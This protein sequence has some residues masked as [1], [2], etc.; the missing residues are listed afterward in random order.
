MRLV[1]RIILAALIVVTGVLGGCASP[2][3]KDLQVVRTIPL[4]GEGGWDCI[5]V[6]SAA[7]RA[8][9]ARSTRVMVVDLAEG[10]LAGELTGVSGAHGVALVPDLNLGFATSGK[11]GMVIVFELKT[12][13][14]IRKIKAGEKPD[15]ILFDPSCRKVFALNHGSGD[16]TVIDP[17][18]LGAAPATIAVGGAL[19]FGAVD[20]K[21]RL[22]VN[23]EDKSEVVAIDIKQGKVIAHWPVGPGEE[24]TGLD[25]D[26]Q[27]RRLFVGCSNRKM[28]VLD[29]DSGKVLADVPVG[30]GVDGVAFDAH[31]GVVVV[32]NGR[33]G[34]AT[35]VRAFAPFAAS[36]Y[37]VY[38]PF[39]AVQTIPT[40]KSA[41]TIAVDPT[42]HRFYL[43]CTQPAD[44]T[45]GAFGIIVV[46]Q[47]DGK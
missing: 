35:V 11:D 2:A 33:D 42:K 4:G 37:P 6:D 21:G 19:E 32:P 1:M 41:R 12:L 3:A 7:G 9:I 40:A 5:T 22:Y 34:T 43:P 46:G 38:L 18:N 28:I 17:A 16:I 24:P 14:P 26:P 20:G 27:H 44:G 13:A 8:Y 25:I 23:V 15:I 39:E 30:S 31:L 47:K 10:R 45:K 36:T 29:A